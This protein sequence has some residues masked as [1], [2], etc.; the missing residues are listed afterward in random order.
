MDRYFEYR[1]R[2]SS[3]VMPVWTAAH[4]ISRDPADQHLFIR[5][6][7]RTVPKAGRRKRRLA[8]YVRQSKLK[9]ALPKRRK[10]SGSRRMGSLICRPFRA[11][12]SF[13]EVRH[14]SDSRL[15]V[16]GHGACRRDVS[17]RGVRAVSRS[18]HAHRPA[19]PRHPVLHELTHQWFGDLV[20]M[21]WFD[22]LWLK[23]G[24]AEYM[25]YQTLAFLETG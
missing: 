25:A 10:F 1:R 15:R 14:G 3:I 13:S 6:C 19:E 16:R 9:S 8:L 23:E 5:V 2:G 18:A 17:S 4:H 21:R 12:F 24:F 7:R 20:T 22:D 11:T